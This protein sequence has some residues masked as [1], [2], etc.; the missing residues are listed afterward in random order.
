MTLLSALNASHILSHIFAVPL[1][2]LLFVLMIRPNF[3]A[4]GLVMADHIA[5]DA[6]VNIFRVAFSRLVAYF[7]AFEAQFF[8]AFERIMGVLSTQNAIKQFPLV[9]TVACKM[10]KLLAVATLQSRVVVLV[11]ATY[12]GLQFFVIICRV[13]L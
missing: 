7:V 2:F 6:G 1:L 5:V 10:S 3:E 12:L 8:G 9:R 4:S 11:V 13:S